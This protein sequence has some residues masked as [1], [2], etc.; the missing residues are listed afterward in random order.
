M[1]RN[2][3]LLL[4][5]PFFLF[6]KSDEPKVMHAQEYAHQK[7][8]SGGSKSIKE[9]LFLSTVE[10]T[11][12]ISMVILTQATSEVTSKS[13]YSKA[14]LSYIEN[15]RIEITQNIA[16]G[17][18]EYLET[19]LTMLELKKDKE[20]LEKIQNKFDNLIYLSHNDFLTQLEKIIETKS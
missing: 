4:A 12:Q 7:Y 14:H 13:H 17:E 16:K 6:A 10:I 18:G 3:L 11:A 9:G 1:K 20:S 2:S 5:L 8:Y 15:N 19:L